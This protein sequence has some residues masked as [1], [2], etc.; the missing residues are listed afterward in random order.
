M[1]SIWK[2]G[3]GGGVDIV[4][5]SAG[6]TAKRVTRKLRMQMF[7]ATSAIL[8]AYKGFAGGRL[9]HRKHSSL[10]DTRIW[11]ISILNL[12]LSDVMESGSNSCGTT[13]CDQRLEKQKISNYIQEKTRY[14]RTGLETGLSAPAFR[15]GD[16]HW[17]LCST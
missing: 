9:A 15:G 5:R 4:G 14:A 1:L 6:P 16:F 3:R 11:A 12:R 8:F 2:G 17:L 13:Q 7:G 10:S